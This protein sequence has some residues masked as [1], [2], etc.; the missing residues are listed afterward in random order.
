M[1]IGI[2]LGHCLSGAD[3]SAAG[4]IVESNLNRN[5]YP[6]L[7]RELENRGHKVIPCTVDSAGSIS[8]SLRGRVNKANAQTLDIFISIHGNAGGG[9]G[10]ET[11]ICSRS[12]YSS[13]SSYNKNKSIAEAVNSKVV[14]SCGFKNRGVKVNDFYV[15]VNTNALALLLEVC[16]VDSKA[17]VAKLDYVKVAQ[18]IADG[19]VGEVTKPPA[20]K[21]KFLKEVPFNE[22]YYLKKYPDVDKH[23]PGT[24]KDGYDH[25]VRY[26]KGEKRIAVPPVPDNFCEGDYKKKNPSVKKAIDNLD[27]NN[28]TE[29]WIQFGW[30][31]PG[32]I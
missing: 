21:Y 7:K 27:F 12:N 16:F 25:Y 3:T 5:I 6:H 29:H 30:K 24:F 23:I 15:L 1:I 31:E 28:C 2:D 26:G 9:E 17:D 8:E 4:V 10:T 22:E 11:Y 19:L 20:R 18:G 14:A 32:R 13:D